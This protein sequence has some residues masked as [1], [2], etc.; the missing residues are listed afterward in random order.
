LEPLNRSGKRPTNLPG[1]EAFDG[2][3]RKLLNIKKVKIDV[4]E[5]EYQPKKRRRKN[6]TTK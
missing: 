5:K 1:L 3:A 2:L 6:S 4:A